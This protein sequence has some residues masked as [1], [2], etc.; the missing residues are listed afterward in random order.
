MHA[1]SGSGIVASSVVLSLLLLSL[2]LVPA[3][4]AHKCEKRDHVLYIDAY[5]PRIYL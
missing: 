3:V 2:V 4:I 5:T 1:L